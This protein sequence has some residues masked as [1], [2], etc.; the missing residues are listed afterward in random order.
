MTLNVIGTGFGRTGTSSLKLAL[1]ELGFGP[2]HHMAEVRDHHDQ[3]A[4]WQKAASGGVV[5]WEQVFTGYR[6]CLDWPA[7]SFW[8]ELCARYPSAKV[9]HTVRDE[10]AWI[11]SMHKTIYRRLMDIEQMGDCYERDRLIMS[12]ELI[13][14]QTFHDRLGDREYAM[15]IFR[16]HTRDVIDAIPAERLLVYDVKQGWGSLCEFLGVA[17]PALSFPRLNST[18]EYRNRSMAQ[19]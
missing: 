12:H 16:A 15:D 18:A 2:C 14:H 17:V 3:L 10:Q 5:D 13:M 6:A 4:W 9:I 1:E 11:D 7:A 19:Q 8:R